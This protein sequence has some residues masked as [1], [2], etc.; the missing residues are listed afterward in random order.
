MRRKLETVSDELER[1]RYQKTLVERTLQ[2]KKDEVRGLKQQYTKSQE[3]LP[4][5]DIR[6]PRGAL[7][8][9]SLDAEKKENAKLIEHI[10][11]IVNFNKRFDSEVIHQD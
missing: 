3:R 10:N 4:E 5:D 9:E 7:I 2:D 8:K 1:V 11:E 6:S